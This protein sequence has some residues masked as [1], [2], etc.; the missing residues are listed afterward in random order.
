MI[1]DEI[2]ELAAHL[3][4]DVANLDGWT[5]EV[6]HINERDPDLG[7]QLKYGVAI[8]LE[9]NRRWLLRIE[10]FQG[11]GFNTQ[12]VEGLNQLQDVIVEKDL[13]VWPPCPSHEH[14]LVPTER[15]EE[16]FWVCP[17]DDEIRVRVGDL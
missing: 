13:R 1:E 3:S 16:L 11:E 2:A 10:F 5:I 7:G 8:A 4:S 9:M 6:V 17:V 14:V 15:S 12:A